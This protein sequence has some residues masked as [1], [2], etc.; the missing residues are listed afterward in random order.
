MVLFIG[1]QKYQN[2]RHQKDLRSQP[3]SQ[4]QMTDIEDLKAWVLF[5]AMPAIFHPKIEK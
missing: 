3:S 5:P 2:W 4:S 1:L